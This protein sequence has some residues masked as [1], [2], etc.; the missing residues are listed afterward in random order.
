MVRQPLLYMNNYYMMT[1]IRR[2][3]DKND[4]NTEK[5]YIAIKKD[6]KERR[7]NGK[8]YSQ[9]DSNYSS[10]PNQPNL[11][12]EK[13]QKLNIEYKPITK[14]DINKNKKNGSDNVSERKERDNLDL[15]NNEKND[16]T[17]NKK[18]GKES[19][20]T[21]QIESPKLSQKE[22][23]KQ[24]TKNSEKI[25]VKEKERENLMNNLAYLSI[26][27]FKEK[28]EEKPIKKFKNE[29][30]YIKRIRFKNENI[31][32]LIKNI[33]DNQKENG[34]NKINKYLYKDTIDN[35]NKILKQ[36]AKNLNNNNTFNYVINV[37]YIKPINNI[38]YIS[39]LKIY[40]S[41]KEIADKKIKNNSLLNDLKINNALN[42]MQIIDKNNFENNMRNNINKS[43]NIENYKDK[44]QNSN[45]NSSLSEKISNGNN[46]V[47]HSSE[48]KVKTKRNFYNININDKISYFHNKINYIYFI[49]LLNLFV[50]KN[51]QE[52]Y[53]YKLYNYYKNN[54]NI[55]TVKNLNLYNNFN[56]SFPFY[57]R[58]LKRLFIYC[59]KENN[60]NRRLKCFLSLIFPSLSKNK[61]L[62]YLLTCL[63]IENKKKL[64]LT[65]LYN[66][67]NEQNILIQF[68]DD[69]AKFDKQISNKD[70]I[71]DKV[72]NTTFYNTNIFTL[73]K[74]VD[75]EYSKLKNGKYC[76][77]CYK[78]E[79]LCDCNKK[80]FNNYISE[81][82]L[83]DLDINEDSNSSRKIL[84]NCFVN[85]DN[86]EILRKN[87]NKNQ[88]ICI[89]KKSNM[90]NI[91][92][93]SS[94]TLMFNNKD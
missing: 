16:K 85:D 21:F 87:K 17:R 6:L 41:Y 33:K 73:V 55:S 31:I 19:P 38:C 63:T 44:D 42:K 62:Y 57:I 2:Y 71:T 15:N 25:T 70:F 39:K 24:N 35:S 45:L 56:F 36:K 59:K 43:I 5:E 81:D 29:V 46:I 22:S 66:V 30:C 86:E 82:D 8:N 37:T 60:Q 89:K 53:F 61:T 93:N 72:T 58:V 84:I 67:N 50:I 79:N 68:L 14:D 12:K 64:Y 23:L 90:N 80:F 20:K 48:S 94:V 52:Y 1:K 28:K 32:K 7:Q 9:E 47:S 75:N 54:Y 65:N 11:E 34:I 13:S 74:F 88:I 18:R 27:S 83:I 26:K 91:D 10:P 69:F 49:Q 3:N 78:Y 40:N 4:F 76:K 92:N 51:T 77:K